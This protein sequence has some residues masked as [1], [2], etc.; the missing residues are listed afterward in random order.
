MTAITPGAV[1]RDWGIAP[2]AI[3]RPGRTA[4]SSA[5]VFNGVGRDRLQ[6]PSPRNAA[7]HVLTIELRSCCLGFEVDGRPQHDGPVPQGA[8]QV[9]R[10]GEHPLARVLGTWRLVQF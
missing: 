2:G 3:A 5:A 1:A 6:L 10:A 7:T 9:V 8:V 4:G